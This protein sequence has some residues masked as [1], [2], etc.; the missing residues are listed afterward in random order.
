MESWFW[1]AV[2]EVFGKPIFFLYTLPALACGVCVLVYIIV[3]TIQ[4]FRK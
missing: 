2:T 4:E 1:G 3:K